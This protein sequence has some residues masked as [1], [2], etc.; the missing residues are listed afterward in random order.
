MTNEAEI[1]EA[2]KIDPEFFTS[3]SLDAISLHFEDEKIRGLFIKTV[4]EVLRKRR[5]ILNTPYYQQ[6]IKA[7]K[8]GKHFNE[9]ALLFHFYINADNIREQEETIVLFLGQLIYHRM[10]GEP[11]DHERDYGNSIQAIQYLIELDRSFMQTLFS[12]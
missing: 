6:A 7:L 5:D 2:S 12:K 1:F 11:F 10:I 8:G 4:N 3:L 9:A